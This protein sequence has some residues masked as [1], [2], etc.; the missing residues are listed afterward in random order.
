[1]V[2]FPFHFLWFL[3]LFRSLSA[4]NDPSLSAFDKEPDT[5]VARSVQ[6][7]G[8]GGGVLR[9]FSLMCPLPR[10][11]LSIALSR[12]LAADVPDETLT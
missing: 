2:S 5:A 6:H 4:S 8:G 7:Q 12:S 11:D 9:S 1:M 3:G 10:E